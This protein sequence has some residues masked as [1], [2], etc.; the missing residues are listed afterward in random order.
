MEVKLN[1]VRTGKKRKNLL[2][3][4]K[5]RYR[6]RTFLSLILMDCFQLET[7]NFFLISDFLSGMSSPAS[8]NIPIDLLELVW[9]VFISHG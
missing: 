8:N 6:G 2:P 4:K 7:S 9:N 1:S 5:N 3:K